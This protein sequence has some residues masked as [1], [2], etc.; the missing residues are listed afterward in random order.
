M[1]FPWSLRRRRSVGDAALPINDATTDSMKSLDATVSPVASAHMP[2]QT[3]PLTAFSPRGSVLSASQRDGDATTEQTDSDDSTAK[4]KPAPLPVKQAVAAYFRHNWIAVIYSGVALGLTVLLLYLSFF[5]AVMDDGLGTQPEFLSCRSWAYGTDCGLWGFNCLPFVTEWSAIRCR[6]RCTMDQSSSLAVWGSGQYHGN[7]R[8]CR[9]AVH[10]GVIGANGGCALMRFAGPANSFAGSTANGVTTESFASWFPKT[11]EFKAAPSRFCTDLTWPILVVSALLC[12]GFALLPR[13]NAAMLYATL[14]G[15]GFFYVRLVGQPQSV[16]Y[17]GI[18]ISSFGEVFVLL[19][20]SYWLFTVAPAETFSQ[21]DSL[22]LRQRLLLWSLC[23]VVPYFVLLNMNMF[24]YI[25]GL[26]VNLGGYQDTHVNAGTYVAIVLVALFMLYCA[27]QFLRELYRQGRWRR[28]L[29]WYAVIG[30][31]VLLT[32]VLFNSTDFHLHHTM[33]GAMLIPLTRFP[34]PLAAVAQSALL[35]CFV[36]GYAAWGWGSYL[37]TKRTCCKSALLFLTSGSDVFLLLCTATYLTIDKPKAA[38]VTNVTRSS[39]NFSW[40]PLK[41]VDGYSLR[42]NKVEVYRGIAPHA[43]VTGLQA[44]MTY[45]ATVAGVA[46]WGT[47]GQDGPKTNFTTLV[48]NPVVYVDEP[49][50]A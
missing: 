40:V 29:L 18:A 16:D 33:L 2:L 43:M 28:L 20:A 36:Q 37:N 4:A 22:A 3:Q 15:W 10:A 12:M 11:F 30:A 21:W 27:F 23:Y 41:G 34:T 6:S 9:A 13:T 25:S 19:A 44:N 42:L 50:S 17:A 31:A 5:A 7:S 24:E 38:T 45:F 35:G 39:A 26:S 1:R 8:I 14:V 49:G 32:W 46:G 47:D 48:E